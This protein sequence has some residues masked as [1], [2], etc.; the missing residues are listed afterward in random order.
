MSAAPTERAHDAAKQAQASTH[1]G[2]VSLCLCSAWLEIQSLEL[3]G[4][5]LNGYLSPQR[6]AT[7]FAVHQVQMLRLEVC[8]VRRLR[9]LCS[10]WRLSGHLGEAARKWCPAGLRKFWN[11]VKR[12]G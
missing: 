12:R 8:R 1:L 6:C 3:F 2:Q 5:E 10:R 11:E 4:S 7:C 9:L